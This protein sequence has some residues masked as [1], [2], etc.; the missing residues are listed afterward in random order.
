M[1]VEDA[2]YQKH[3]VF[4]DIDYYIAFYKKLSFAV[5]SWI[6]VGTT[7][8]LN[9]DTYVY[10]SIQGTLSSI[11]N[12]LHNGRITDAYALL[13]KY[14]DSIVINIYTNVFLE[15]KISLENLIVKQI[16][17]W[18][19]GTAKMPE[20]RIMSQFIQ[21]SKI[22]GEISQSL[23]GDGRYKAIRNRCNDATHYN[24][25][26][27]ILINDN[28]IYLKN[29]LSILDEFKEDLKN[30]I[31]LHFAL[32]FFIKGNYMMASDHR[33]ALDLGATPEPESEYWVAPFIQD[34]FDEVIAKNRPDLAQIIKENTAMKLA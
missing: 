8:L 20:Y 26:K 22:M 18:L 27:F 9:I 33:D 19:K 1:H 13:R 31:I 2:S 10:S 21:K 4:K 3:L 6:T 32:L 29:R 16:D 14:H 7:A 11:K 15:E 34:F 25:Y 30:L 5:M 28:E 23:F 24:F 12:I 17:D